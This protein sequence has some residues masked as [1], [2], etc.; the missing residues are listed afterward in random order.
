M[1]SG[2]N[3]KRERISPSHRARGG[4]GSGAFRV[5]GA[6]PIRQKVSG[7]NF[8][9]EKKKNLNLKKGETKEWDV[10]DQ[11]AQTAARG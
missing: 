2:L 1:R 10:L 3:N 8:P 7:S 6:P 11:Q 9:C 4:Q 5:G